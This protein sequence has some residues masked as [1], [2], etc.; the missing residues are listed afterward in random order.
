MSLGLVRARRIPKQGLV[1]V[2]AFIVAASLSMVVVSY[3]SAS[4]PT[5]PGYWLVSSSG[6]VSAYGGAD[7]LGS[8]KASGGPSAVVGIASTPDAGG[9]WLAAAD[10]QV[11][12]FGD[13]KTFGSMAGKR[14]AKPLVGI[15]SSPDGRGYWLLGSD[16][17]VFAFGDAG[18]FGSAGAAHLGSSAVAMAVAPGGH[19][20]WLAT[21]KGAILRFGDVGIGA[22]RVTGLG[23]AVVDMVATPDAK[24]YW[25]VTSR[26]Q[27][28]AYGDAH[29]YGSMDGARL[30]GTVV[31]IAPTSDGKGYWLAARDGGVFSFG[32]AQF[33][34]SDFAKLVASGR[35][36]GSSSGESIRGIAPRYYPARPIHRR[37]HGTAPT[38]VPTTSAPTTVPTTMTPTTV[39][40]TTMT[41]TTV[42]TTMTPTTM[43]PTT[44]TPTTMTPTTMTPTTVPTTRTPTTRTPTTM[45][46]TTTLPPTTATTAPPTTAP[47]TTVATANPPAAG[48]N[49][50]NPAY[51]SSEASGTDPIDSAGFW[52]VNNDA[53]SGS[54]GPQTINV[55][56]QSSWDAVSDQPDVQGQVETYPDTEYDVGSRNSPSTEPIS[57]FNSITSTFSEAYPSAGSWDAGYDLWTNNWSNE[58]MIWNQYAGGQAYWYGQGTPVTI[59]GV[60]YH[61]VDNGSCTP[62]QCPASQ[63]GG[64][65]DHDE[66]M[67]IMS[68]QETS[69]AVNLLSIFQWEVANGYANASDVPTQLE[70]GVEICS[71]SGAETFPMTGLTFNVS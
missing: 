22:A 49:C 37:G 45:A 31:G 50:T 13:A 2:I 9:Y 71:T 23:S 28:L 5:G 69:G 51:S 15:S 1:L 26:G 6:A 25:L 40:P 33:M 59:D 44:M 3:G 55:C 17:G 21:T 42:P 53:W 61:F 47:P 12:A 60:Q 68:N 35:H 36:P 64:P 52:W 14:L 19:G 67:F 58:T 16:G 18:Y 70:Y 24:G 10:G 30:N 20:Y 34:G 43:T 41:P 65:T 39:T 48:G 38:T 56:N 57:Q 54:H 11:H 46:P 66:L 63:G 8:V 29:Y 32:D 27:V 7:P 4:S 62:V